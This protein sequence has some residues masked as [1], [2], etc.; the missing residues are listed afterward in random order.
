MNKHID[1][2]HIIAHASSLLKLG[3]GEGTLL[4]ESN[5]IWLFMMDTSKNAGYLKVSRTWKRIQN[6]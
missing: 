2:A 4:A 5:T 3:A 6:P 1:K